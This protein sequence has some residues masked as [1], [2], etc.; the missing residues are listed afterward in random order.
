MKSRASARRKQ[1]SRKTRSA[2]KSFQ[3]HLAGQV[4]SFFKR[5]EPEE[6]HLERKHRPCLERPR[7]EISVFRISGASIA[8]TPRDCILSAPFEAPILFLSPP[9]PQFPGI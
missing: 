8:K 9:I 2:R 3:I 7:R 1:R 6:I 4:T 5:K